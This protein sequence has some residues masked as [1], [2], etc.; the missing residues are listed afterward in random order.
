MAVA[1]QE[2]NA[3][4]GHVRVEALVKDYRVVRGKPFVVQIQL[5]IDKGFHINSNSPH[6]KFLIPTKVT[7]K[8]VPDFSFK[9]VKFPAAVERKFEFSPEKLVV[10]EAEVHLQVEGISNP[11]SELGKKNISGQLQ[12]QACDENTCYPPKRVPFEIPV[13]VVQ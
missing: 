1:F 8:N 10:F 6:D 4:P 2:V 9:E 11:K 5:T 13:E 7:F 3:Q 12:Y